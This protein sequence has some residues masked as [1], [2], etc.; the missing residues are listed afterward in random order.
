MVGIYKITNPQGKIYIGQSINIEE[1]LYQ[2]KCLSKYSL[3]RKI[4]NSIKKYGWENHSHEVIIECLIEE[5]DDK[6]IYWG[7]FYEVLGENG[8]NLKLG[9]GRGKCSNETKAL[10]SQRAKEIMTEEHKKKLSKAKLGKK[11]SEKAKQALRVPKNSNINYLNNVGKWPSRTTSVLQYDKQGNF[12]KEW[13]TILEAE[14]TFHP[15]K[16]KGNNIVCCCK[17]RQKTAYGY[18]WKYKE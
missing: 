15:K 17:G 4:Y 16:I 1:R 14:L 10:M 18:I 8:L 7:E 6:E 5:L 2:Y 11:R 12:I 9:E 3:G 13:D